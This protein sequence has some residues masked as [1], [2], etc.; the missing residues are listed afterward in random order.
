MK[1]DSKYQDIYEVVKQIPSGKVATYGQVAQ[2]AGR[3]NGA[4]QV[5]YA[6]AALSEQH[7]VPWHRVV[8]AKGKISLRAIVGYEDY[9]RILL[10]DEGVLFDD[11]NTIDLGEFLWTS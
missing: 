4:R 8:N 11:R 3:I 2:L 9:Q 6:L 10:E 7:D 5:G 1:Q